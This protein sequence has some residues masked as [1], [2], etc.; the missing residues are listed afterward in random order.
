MYF[1]I[2]KFANFVAH[3][4]FLDGSLHRLSGLD[5]ASDRIAVTSGTVEIELG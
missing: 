1:S 5:E 2:T 4:G 3:R